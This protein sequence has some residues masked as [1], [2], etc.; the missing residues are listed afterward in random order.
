MPESVQPAPDPLPSVQPAKD[1]LPPTPGPSGEAPPTV[2]DLPRGRGLALTL[3]TS[4]ALVVALQWSQPVL[5]PV[6]IGVLLAYALEP[7]VTALARAKVPRSIGAGIVLLLFGGMLAGGV[8]GLSGQ[9]LQIVRQVPEASQRLRERFRAQE[10]TPGALGEVQKAATELQKTAEVASQTSEG[11]REPGSAAVQKVQIVEPAFDAR[12]TLYWGGMNLLAATGQVAVIMFLVYFFLVTG[13]L[14]KRKIVKIAG[15]ALWQKKLT[16]QILDEINSQISSFI[17]VQLFTS[18]VV[19][20]ATA[21]VLWYFGVNQY[22]IWGL[23]AGI[24]NS[25]PYLGPIAVSGGLAVVA[26]MQFDDVGR[27]LVV[28]GAAFVITSLEGFLLTPALMGRAARMNPVA[29]F[30]GLLFWGWIWGVWG[31]VL[32]VPMLMMIKAVCDHIEDLQPVGELLGE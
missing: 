30:V 28:A 12:G 9:A 11:R 13:D 1:P 29:I 17:R 16:V 2:V 6:V 24:F 3:L 8:Y 25:I 19:A 23:L 21:A 32:A 14:Y 27:A 7:F 15:P 4:I 10:R 31:A 26:F 18:L 5:I 22:I 20:V